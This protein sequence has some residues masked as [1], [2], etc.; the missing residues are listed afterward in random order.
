MKRNREEGGRKGRKEERERN[1]GV[2]V[3]VSCLWKSPASTGVSA[4]GSFGGPSQRPG[5]GAGDASGNLR[6]AF[7]PDCSKHPWGKHWSPDNCP[8]PRLAVS[9]GRCY[10]ISLRLCAC[11]ISVT[12]LGGLLGNRG[13]GLG[14]FFV[15]CFSLQ[16]IET[17]VFL[18]WLNWVSRIWTQQGRNLPNNSGGN[19]S[20]WKDLPKGKDHFIS[21]LLEQ[22][23]V[24]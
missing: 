10:W 24:R 12:Q 14:L 23:T 19:I 20:F 17:I 13:L 22:K 9:R 7:V 1:R 5:A 21:V 18:F 15:F 16:I 4:S 11:S 8:P 6:R 2:L 3:E